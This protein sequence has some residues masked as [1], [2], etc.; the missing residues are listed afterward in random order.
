[1]SSNKYNFGNHV[2]AVEHEAGV[3]LKLEG[4]LEDSF[5]PILSS[6]FSWHTLIKSCD[7]FL[8]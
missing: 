4:M 2:D 3:L 8:D 7:F 6:T 5:K 1:M